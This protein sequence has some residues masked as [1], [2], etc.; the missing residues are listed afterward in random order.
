MGIWKSTAAALLVVLAGCGTPS[1]QK[2]ARAKDWESP[3]FAASQRPAPA[4]IQPAPPMVPVPAVAPVHIQKH[5]TSWL[6]LDRWC[7]DNQRTMPTR[8][9]GTPPAYSL[10]A[11]N[12]SLILRSGTTSAFWSGSEVRLGFAP[13]FIDG[14]L[15]VHGLDL[16]KTIDPLLSQWT[17][18][19]K[20]S[21]P[22]I[23]LDPGHGGSDPGARAAGTR[24]SEKDLTLDWALRLSAVLVANGWQ[25]FLTR[26]NDSS[27]ALSN[28]V[29]FADAHRANFFISLHFNSSTQGRE[30]GLETYCLTPAGMQSSITRGEDD[31]L[32]SFPNNAFDAQ[33]LALAYRVHSALL[34]ATTGHDRGVRRARFP[35]VLR[36][37]S[38]P[39]ILVEGGYI[40][41]PEEA[42]HIINPVYR[43]KLAEAIVRALCD[44]LPA[45]AVSETKPK[46]GN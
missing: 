1:A 28:R 6:S 24:W 16:E 20:A 41:N 34:H 37:Q 25:V 2:S 46:D 27:L 14:H 13:Q 23:V 19:P 32:A 9:M 39:A 22:V 43:Q 33:N 29:A 7:E 15:F 31:L 36:N 26:T 12:G 11:S 10:N 44:D 17:P 5:E 38:R 40:S 4:A 42:A 8:L 35:G 3:E 45:L 21:R 18:P 30:H